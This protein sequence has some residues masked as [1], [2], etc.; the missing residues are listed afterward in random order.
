MTEESLRLHI[1]KYKAYIDFM[2]SQQQWSGI[3]KAEVDQWLDNFRY[4][5]SYELYLVYKLFANIIYFSEKDVLD[6]LQ[7]GI[8]ARLFSD[9]ILKKQKDNDFSCSQKSLKNSLNEELNY[10]IF[11]PLLDKNAPHESANYV[12]RLLVQHGIIDQKQSVF[13]NQIVDK[14][15]NNP[16]SNLIIIDDCVGSGDQLRNFWK[17]SFVIENGTSISLDLFCRKHNVK[18]YYLSL[19]GYDLSIESLQREFPT[20]NICCVHLLSD[21]QRV[22]S[23]KSYIWANKQE[24]QDALMLFSE[25][26][27][28]VGIKLYGYKELDF[29]FI[30]H[31]TIPN[32]SLPLFWQENSDWKLLLRRKNSNG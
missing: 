14:W 4:L 22:F 18:A 6:A 23:E 28:N 9:I 24:R 10:S 16:F 29:A 15:T 26:T 7:E 30:M 11:I 5:N 17:K 27:D 31:Q 1:D 19:F 3:T 8:N 2:L 13:L 25:I 32:W 21:D 20:L 12:T